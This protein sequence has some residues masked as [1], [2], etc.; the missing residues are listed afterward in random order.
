M[1]EKNKKIRA[2]NA[3]DQSKA[4]NELEDKCN[5]YLAGWKRALAD[6]ENLKQDVQKQLSDG[7]NR[8]KE[9][10]AHELL[11]VV[12]NFQQAVHHIPPPEADEATVAGWLQG[13]TFIA[14]QFEDVMQ[15]MGI[16]KI[17]TIGRIFD[18]NEHEAVSTQT[19]ED[20]SDQEIL[21]EITQGWKMGD[22]VIRPAKVIINNLNP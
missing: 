2:N 12:D 11:P 10:L 15:S 18:P 4:T 22:A 5:E 9:S 1:K 16:E 20:K 8:I 14:K 17:V 7:R 6:Y 3:A 19:E 13:V 21:E